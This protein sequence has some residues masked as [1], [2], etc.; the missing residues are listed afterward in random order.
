MRS[1]RII[2]ETRFDKKTFYLVQ[3]RCK[4]LPIWLTYKEAIDIYESSG[5]KIFEKDRFYSLERAR[6]IVQS[7][8]RSLERN[9]IVSSKVV[10]EYSDKKIKTIYDITL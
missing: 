7:D 3:R 2:E 5:W 10:E 6:E 1:Y 9:K 8:I 4:F